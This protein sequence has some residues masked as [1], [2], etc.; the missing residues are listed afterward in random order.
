ML[1]I[2]SGQHSSGI[3]VKSENMRAVGRLLPRSGIESKDKCDTGGKE[4]K[5]LISVSRIMGCQ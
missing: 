4:T 2:S 1:A 5:I 3:K